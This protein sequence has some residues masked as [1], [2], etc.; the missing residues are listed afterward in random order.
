[1]MS[2]ACGNLPLKHFLLKPVQR[3][4]QYKWLLTDYQR[5]L[6]PDSSSDFTDTQAALEIISEVAAHTSSSIRQGDN[7]QKLMHLQQKL[8]GTEIVRPGRTLLKEGTLLK[9]CR[10]DLQPRVFCLMNDVLLYTSP[11]GGGKLKL[12]RIFSLTT[13]QVYRPV[14]EAYPN[15]F[16]L[17][18][19]ERSFVLTAS[20]PQERDEW[21]HAIKRAV[22]DDAQKRATFLSPPSFTE[23]SLREVENDRGATGV[24]SP[25]EAPSSRCTLCQTEFSLASHPYCCHSCGKAVCHICS[26]NNLPMRRL[27]EKPVKVCNSCFPP[28]DDTSDS[29][30][31]ETSGPPA[32]P[33]RSFPGILNT[34]KPRAVPGSG[35]GGGTCSE[36]STMLGFVE[37]SRNGRKPWKQRWLELHN[38]MLFVYRSSEAISPC[39]SLSITGLTVTVP[40]SYGNTDPGAAPVVTFQLLQRDRVCFS[41]RADA[42]SAQRW[43]ESLQEEFL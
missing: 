39:D 25:T 10:K 18:S 5:Y 37:V 24:Q 16:H 22:E 15:E 42:D 36:G 14:T 41:L 28:L 4:P 26:K 23:P 2:P 6:T 30:S 19:L 31:V 32:S 12:N 7:F 20:S 17:L 8:Q 1:M 29:I 34:L 43:A 13:V 3:I 11:Q 38:R 40:V 33:R 21:I 35:M 27:R 9:L